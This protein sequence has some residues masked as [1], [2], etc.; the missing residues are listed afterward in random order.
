MRKTS[1]RFRGD[2]HSSKPNSLGSSGGKMSSLHGS[3]WR[4]KL[5]S[6]WLWRLL[7]RN[8]HIEFLD[9]IFEWKMK[10]TWRMNFL[11]KKSSRFYEGSKRESV[12]ISS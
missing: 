8:V 10:L 5:L 4:S 7:L 12:T 3:I 11:K 6:E 2:S 9:G 1:I